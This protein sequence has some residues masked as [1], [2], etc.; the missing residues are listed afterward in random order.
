[1]TQVNANTEKMYERLVNDWSTIFPDGNRNAAGP[2]FFKYI[3]DHFN[4]IM[5]V[6]DYNGGVQFLNSC[7]ESDLFKKANLKIGTF[8]ADFDNL[9]NYSGALREAKKQYNK[10][11]NVICHLRKPTTQWIRYAN[12]LMQSAFDY[13]KMYFAASAMDENYTTQ[14]NKKI[15]IANLKF[16]RHADQE[17]NAGA[18]MIDFIEHQKDMIDLTKAECAL[19]NVSTSVGGTQ[20]F[21]LPSNLKRQKGLD[22]TRKDSYSALLLGYWGVN[23]YFDMME[24][25]KIENNGFT[26]MFL[27]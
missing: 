2:R 18:K 3:L 1:M 8:D 25:P 11:T 21:D 23:M 12:E 26:P 20:S 27:N 16:S 24:M 7:N 10:T 9:K 15:P 13:K 4:I 19:I 6:G 14:R 5:I 17:K 22:R